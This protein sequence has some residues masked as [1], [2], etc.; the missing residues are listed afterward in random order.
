MG[1]Y[2]VKALER[3]KTDERVVPHRGWA[4]H[5]GRDTDGALRLS[6][7]ATEAS[8]RATGAGGRLGLLP[9]GRPVTGRGEEASPAR[10]A[11]EDTVALP[12]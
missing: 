5:R 10:M 8:S 1:I 7:R 2:I 12:S 9:S 11:W 6:S 3:S 4:G